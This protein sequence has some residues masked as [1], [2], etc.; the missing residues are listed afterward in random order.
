MK[1]VNGKAKERDALAIYR[2]EIVRE[3]VYEDPRR[4]AV[5]ISK[6]SR[7]THSVLELEAATISDLVETINDA[8]RLEIGESPI[9]FSSDHNKANITAFSYFRSET[10]TGALASSEYVERWKAGEVTLFRVQYKIEIARATPIAIE[11]FKKAGLKS[12]D[13]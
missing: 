7:I 3:A 2:I 6:S 10:N 12:V 8:F 4:G 9:S 1:C 13:F 11:E 5:G